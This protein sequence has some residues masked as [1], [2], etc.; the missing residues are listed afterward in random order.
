MMSLA[1]NFAITCRRANSISYSLLFIQR[2]EKMKMS[3]AKLIR[4][5]GLLLLLVVV[6]LFAFVWFGTYHPANIEPMTVTCP[7]SAPT[8]QSGQSLKV[9]T[10]N[11][12]TMSGKNYVFWNDLPNG[13]GPDE[14]PSP[15]DIT[16]TLSEVARVIK[17]ENPD[18]I[19]LEEIDNGAA[20]TDY[21]D[22]FA[23]LKELLPSDFVCSTSAYYW[24]AVYVPHPRI[25]GKV[26]GGM[27]SFV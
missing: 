16:L 9:M 23:R 3:L 10:W 24:K 5:A 27:S 6:A 4:W 14:R 18:I 21:E 25:H 15:E 13:D 22:Q 7:E 17:D 20:R 2:N 12:Q 19:F 26:G 8:V 11:V 1:W